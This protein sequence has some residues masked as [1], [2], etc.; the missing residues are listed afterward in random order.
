MSYENELLNSILG[1]EENEASAVDGNRLIDVLFNKFNGDD[2]VKIKN[3]TNKK[4]GYVYSDRKLIRVEHPNDFTERVYGRGR[5]SAK[6]RVL[7]AGE[8]KIIPGWEA[9]VGLEKFFQQWA[10]DNNKPLF[11]TTSFNEFLGKAYL[12]IV[13]TDELMSSVEKAEKK[14]TAKEELEEDLGFADKDAKKSTK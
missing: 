1:S 7:E 9:M 3:F 4:F 14:V 10:T 8:T 2:L 5:E 13:D 12:G 6:V 11:N